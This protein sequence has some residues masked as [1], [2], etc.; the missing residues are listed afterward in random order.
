MQTSDYGP[1]TQHPNDPRN[2]PEFTCPACGGE[3]DYEGS[4]LVCASCDW[5]ETQEEAED[6]EYGD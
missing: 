6:Y 5:D 3:L 4:L 1:P 2:D